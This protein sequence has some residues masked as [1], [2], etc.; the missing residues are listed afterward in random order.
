MTYRKRYRWLRDPRL[1][2]N[3]LVTGRERNDKAWM[4]I[5]GRISW[6]Y[7]EANNAL[8]KLA[9]RFDVSLVQ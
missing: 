7:Y 5:R 4:M 3:D 8:H 1:A 6:E 2:T 9:A